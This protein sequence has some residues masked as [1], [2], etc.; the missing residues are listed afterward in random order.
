MFVT[1]NRLDIQ[2]AHATIAYTHEWSRVGEMAMRMTTNNE[3]DLDKTQ[4]QDQ[5]DE[6]TFV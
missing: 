2:P 1:V 6:P 5:K 3:D 4:I